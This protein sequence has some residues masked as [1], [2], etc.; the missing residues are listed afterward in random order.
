M[1]KK[2]K[3]SISIILIGLV[4]SNC[5]S[6]ENK[7]LNVANDSLNNSK[8]LTINSE[9]LMNLESKEI[10]NLVANAKKSGTQED[11]TILWRAMLN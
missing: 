1:Y 4:L 5:N 9:K 3:T 6:T 8:E 11:L 7:N 10:D 2:M